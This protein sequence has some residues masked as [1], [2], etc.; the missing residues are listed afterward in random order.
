[1]QAS[2]HA[3]AIPALS[4]KY[5]RARGCF[6]AMRGTGAGGAVE[7]EQHLGLVRTPRDT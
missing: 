2:S 6:M 5:F 4:Q 1:M 3:A 7:E